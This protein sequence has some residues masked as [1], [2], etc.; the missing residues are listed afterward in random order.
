MSERTEVNDRELCVCNHELR[1]HS[2]EAD[3]TRGLCIR[4]EWCHC[5]G[6]RP[7]HV[8]EEIPPPAP[9]M[10]SAMVEVWGAWAEGILEQI[11][12]E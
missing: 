7:Q 8:D 4:D 10:S 11:G 5:P 6:F 12:D 2:L 9:S 3:G 1:L